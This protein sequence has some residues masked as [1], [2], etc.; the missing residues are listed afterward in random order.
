M[1]LSG[2]LGLSALAAASVSELQV[3]TTYAVADCV[4][5]SKNG[6]TLSMHYTGLLQDGTKFD[7]SL[8]RYKLD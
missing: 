6:D 1:K 3:E 4:Q 7:S 2:V 8:D 5:K